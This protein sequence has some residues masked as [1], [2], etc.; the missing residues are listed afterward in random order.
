MP[1]TQKF[2]ERVVRVEKPSAHFKLLRNENGDFLGTS[3]GETAVF[4]H[5]DDKAIWKEEGDT[6]RHVVSGLPLDVSAA[7]DE[8]VHL[9]PEW[10]I[11]GRRRLRIVRTGAFSAGS[12]PCPSPV[13][14]PPANPRERMGLPS[15]H[16]VSPRDRRTAKGELHRQV[17]P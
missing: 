15:E 9:R 4:D 8:G 12:R 14:I 11:T 3:E 17:G 13:R 16:L 2:E 10:E 7:N 1:P 6:Y 5:V